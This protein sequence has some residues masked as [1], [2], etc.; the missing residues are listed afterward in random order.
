LVFIK[1]NIKN[2][3]ATITKIP[4]SKLKEDETFKSVGIDSLMALQLKNKIQTDFNL[5][6]NVSTVWSFPTIEKYAN[7][8]A[9][10]LDLESQFQQ[11]Q[12]IVKNT[13]EAEVE[14]LSLD[15]LMKQLNDK[16]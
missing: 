16:L 1:Q 2:H 8:I 7:F 15:E 14:N 12:Q 11:T 6:L 3:I 13:I 5:N 4:A 9:T 10:E